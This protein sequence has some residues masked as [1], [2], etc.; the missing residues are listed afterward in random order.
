MHG[1][2]A[3]MLRVLLTGLLLSLAFLSACAGGHTPPEAAETDEVAVAPDSTSELQAGKAIRDSAAT[4]ALPLA[5]R[6]PLTPSATPAPGSLPVAEPTPRMKGESAPTPDEEMD[7]APE[8]RGEIGL[9]DVEVEVD[10][11][12]RPSAVGGLALVHYESGA[13]V[14]WS[15]GLFLLDVRTGDVHGWVRPAGTVADG[16]PDAAARDHDAIR[17]SPGNRFVLWTD[18]SGAPVLYDRRGDEAYSW[19]S[20]TARFD[21]WWGSGDAERLLFQRTGSNAFVLMDGNLERVSEFTLPEGERFSSATGGYILV[22]ACIS[23]DPGDR[24]HIVNLEDE[25]NPAIHTLTMPWKM[26]E[27]APS[28]DV[29]Y[30]IELLDNLVTIVADTNGGSCRAVRY[31]LDGALRSDEAVPCSRL[32]PGP[33][34]GFG[35]DRIPPDEGLLDAATTGLLDE[36]GFG[37]MPITRMTAFDAITG[38]EIVR[39]I[40]VSR[41]ANEPDVLKLA[42]SS[43][44]VLGSDT[45]LRFAAVNGAWRRTAAGPSPVD[46]QYAPAP[47]PLV[48]T[49][50]R[51]DQAATLTFAPPAEAIPDRP[52]SDVFLDLFADWGAAGDVLRVRTLLDY[53]QFAPPAEEPTAA[54]EQ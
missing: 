54:D 24:Y 30:Q 18:D 52:G 10:A 3:R 7:A 38:R 51:G 25:T 35:L 17:V 15:P 53:E 48:V 34:A 42:D 5:S 40:T 29:T 33:S 13:D 32:W 26:I 6:A 50:L 28:G 46:P 45:G 9:V 4:R 41:R 22:R 44:L 47:A 19:D 36:T 11:E 8:P 43:A 49:S 31:D 37:E 27:R 2:L 20:A 23:C 16:A 1:I 21:R 14:P 12:G 39:V